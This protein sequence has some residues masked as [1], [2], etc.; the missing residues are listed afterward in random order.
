MRDQVIADRGGV[1]HDDSEQDG[2]ELEVALGEDAHHDDGGQGDDG[3]DPVLR[4]VAQGVRG[5]GKACLL[6]TS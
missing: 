2:D 1:A 5:E 3:D 4:G 6:Y